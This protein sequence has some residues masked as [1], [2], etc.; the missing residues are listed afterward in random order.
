MQSTV[1]KSWI[2]QWFRESGINVVVFV[3]LVIIGLI[4]Y[5][6]VYRGI[7]VHHTI[8]YGS[9]RKSAKDNEVR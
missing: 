2:I 1:S 9:P 8:H 3:V 4:A 7:I 5:S 6:T